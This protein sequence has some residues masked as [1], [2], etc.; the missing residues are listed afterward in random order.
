MEESNLIAQRIE[1]KLRMINNGD[2]EVNTLRAESSGSVGVTSALAKR[3]PQVRGLQ[4]VPG[5]PAS[6]PVPPD[7]ESPPDNVRVSVF[8]ELDEDQDVPTKLPKPTAKRGKLMT[9]ELKQS[10]IQP[11]SNFEGIA[12][13][14]TGD[15]LTHPRP[16]RS[17]EHVNRPSPRSLYSERA[18]KGGE[19]IILGIIDVEGFDFTHPDFLDANGETRFLSIWDQGG[20]GTHPALFAYGAE[21]SQGEMNAALKWSQKHHVGATDLL[22]QSSQIPSA[23]ATHVASIAAGN[24]GVAPKVDIAGVLIALSPDDRD[25]R[26]SFYDSTRLAHAVDYLFALGTKHKKPVVI[27][28]SLGT[29]GHAH[30]GSSPISRWIDAALTVPGRCVCVAAGNAGQ[31]APQFSDDL[32]FM[33]GRIHTSGRIPASGLETDIDWQVVGNGISDGS[34]NELEIWY[35][36]QDRFE[37]MVKSPS[38]EWFG[39][40]GPGKYI[41]N[42]QLKSGTFLSIYNELYHP[43]NGSN[44]IAVYLT[45]RLKKPYIGVEAGTWLVRLRGA[46][47]RDG[48]FHAWIERDDPR[49]LGR[50]GERNVWRFPSYFTQRSNV[51]NSSISSLACGLRI[52]SVANYDEQVE[53]INIS[54]SQGP[55]RDGR[56][57]PEVAA[58]GTNIVAANGFSPAHR[59]WIAMSGTSMAS[60]YVAGVAALMLAVE[61]RL[62][63]PQI[64]GIM[65]K[66]AQPLPGYDYYW[67]DDAGFGRIQPELCLEEAA[68][69]YKQVEVKREGES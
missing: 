25:R 15:A 34:E 58:A 30:D 5:E 26:R 49:P 51:D 44:R 39:P 6:V 18:A 8:V 65:R 64:I 60:P 2:E 12:Y 63:A 57:K 52:V 1:P 23:H 50:V 59:K 28:I 38:G 20:K 61:K 47:I 53:R 13:V 40:L 4:A 56:F 35:E 11:V 3:Y 41:Q 55:T 68:I 9:L 69:A 46:A 27:N 21:L 54:S 16:V 45:P 14:T 33:M 48:R 66:T 7:M 37:I 31:E 29:N 32:G 17:P 24:H 43:H 19:G 22:P 42:Q 62:T 36:P 10:Q 67:Q